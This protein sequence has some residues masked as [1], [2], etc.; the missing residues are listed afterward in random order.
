MRSLQGWRGSHSLTD[1]GGEEALPLPVGSTR[2]LAPLVRLPGEG[3]EDVCAHNF[4]TRAQWRRSLPLRAAGQRESERHVHGVRGFVVT[5]EGHVHAGEL[6][7]AER[8]LD[9]RLGTGVLDGDGHGP[10]VEAGA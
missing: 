1:F 4:L 10:T 9:A 3:D 5:D 2:E 6:P 7:L 8:D